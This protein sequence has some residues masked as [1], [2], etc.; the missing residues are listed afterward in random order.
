[1]WRH[2]F[3]LTLLLS[4]LAFLL[5][6][7]VAAASGTATSASPQGEVSGTIS[8]DTTW[9][10]TG[11]PY[12]V[13]GDVTVNPDITLLI[14]PGVEVRFDGNYAINVQGT[15]DAE[16][17]EAQ[18]IRFTSNQP[19]PTAGDWAMIDFR[20][21]S[22]YSV[23]EH[24]IVEY[25]GNATRAGWY[26]T[27]GALCVHTSSFLL[28]ES[29]VQHNAT[30]GLVLV[31]SDATISNN[32][33]DDHGDEA[34]R[35]HTCDYRIG[36]CRPIIVGNTFTDNASAILR[37]DGQDPFTSGNQASGNEINGLVLWTSC[38][39]RGG[40]TWYADDLTY[41][42]PTGTCSVGG[43]GPASLTIEPGTVVKFGSGAGMGAH[44]TSVLTAT[45]TSDRQIVFT[46]L[47]DDSVGGDTNND[48]SA[49][50]PASDDWSR[51]YIAGAEAR[52]LFEHAVFRY[53]G[54]SG[55]NWGP[56][57]EVDYDA[58]M[59]MRNCH[60]SQGEVGVS[61]A[62]GANVQ[63]EESVI[64][65]NATVGVV[66]NSDGEV[67]IADNRFED[68]GSGVHVSLGHPTV[69]DNFF[70][71]N[72]IAVEV[73]C[74]P[75]VGDCAPVVSPHNR[76][77]GTG[78]EGIVSRYPKELC[79]DARHNW[80][81]DETGPQDPSIGQCACGL[82]DNPGSGAFA[83]DGVDYS[84]WEGGV[85]RPIITWPG[86]GVTAVERPTFIGRAQSGATVSVYDGGQ[87]LGQ[88]VCSADH[89][90]LVTTTTSLTDGQHLVTAL[91]EA[92]GESSLPSK[93]LSLT[94]DSSLDYDPAG[95]LIIYEYHSVVYTQTLRDASGCASPIGDLSTQIQLR[96]DSIMTI[97][98]PIRTS[99]VA[100]W[101]EAKLPVEEDT[102][103]ASMAS[104]Q[105]DPGSF[106]EIDYQITNQSGKAIQSIYFV[107]SGSHEGLKDEYKKPVLINDGDVRTIQAPAGNYD[108]VMIGRDGSI[109]ELDYS[110]SLTA[111][112][113]KT[114]PAHEESSLAL[115]NNYESQKISKVF[116]STS[117]KTLGPNLLK[118]GSTALDPKSVL[119]WKLPKGRYTIAA[120]AED[121]TW[122]LHRQ[123][124]EGT[125]SGKI[126]DPGP[127][128]TV[129]IYSK[130]DICELYIS[131]STGER[132]PNLVTLLGVDRLEKM[133]DYQIKLARGTYSLTAVDC[134]GKVRDHREN[135][136]PPGFYLWDVGDPCEP[137]GA[138]K[139]I[140][141]LIPEFIKKHLTPAKP[142]GR[143][144]PLNWVMYGVYQIVPKGWKE[145]PRIV[146]LELCDQH[147]RQTINVGKALIDPDG[148]VY[149]AL[150]GIDGRI[151]GA[152][153]TCDT[154]DEDLEW[155]DRW[156]A[157]LYESQI[158]PQITGED[159]YYAFFVP[160]GLYRVRASATGYISHTSPNIRVI[161][162]IVHYN[163]PLEGGT[164]SCFLPLILK[165]VVGQ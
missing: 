144:N 88:G 148:Y 85:A 84:P 55:I 90:F 18:P 2:R 42:V 79:V 77:V 116:L 76:F 143:Y 59:T 6:L 104:A 105:A 7:S 138:V 101:Q 165:E 137:P 154:Y 31:Q 86:C 131:R 93:P 50:S 26:C 119:S 124:I 147:R 160:P 157:E 135:V 114:V 103:T 8:E 139:F 91:A 156:R 40:N 62:R 57:V 48:G 3:P 83:S 27:S 73:I 45:G 94:V 109:V 110:V 92:G 132:G 127:G 70:Q 82:V 71:G 52:A 16:G 129:T 150:I 164:V 17:T 36:P 106:E 125:K 108:I 87:L 149:D 141:S 113:S 61:V 151:Q 41:V 72:A 9:T 66:I 44:A 69:C 115:T 163:I 53:G 98:V 1:M 162:E 122:H 51:V 60:L 19:T 43:Y 22:K 58:T 33:F 46:S 96:P 37:Y 11:S 68:T 35:L 95:I 100:S 13:T 75:P 5:L 15:L 54:G 136:Q 49:T 111:G 81:G 107:P 47:K 120:Q 30:R 140:N 78:Q 34:I 24:T 159:G 123:D 10:L 12:V 64:R 23:L 158:N 102:P 38:V 20:S 89:S 128:R 97:V 4:C 65:D 99:F 39:F 121:G 74:S 28:N 130:Y 126:S 32:T 145:A 133:V 153:V 25:G 21:D 142:T 134:E 67:L 29:T 146:H 14:E 118:P 161:S 112:S 117:D 155:W 152:T 80:W 63:I 56:L